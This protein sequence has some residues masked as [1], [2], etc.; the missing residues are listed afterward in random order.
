MT[1][2]NRWA[3]PTVSDVAWPLDSIPAYVN[4]DMVDAALAAGTGGPVAIAAIGCTP[5]LV[6]TELEGDTDPVRYWICH[7]LLM[8]TVA[9]A[10]AGL[11]VAMRVT[12]IGMADQKDE[13]DSVRAEY[14][15]RVVQYASEC[16]KEAPC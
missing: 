14:L 9:S 13:P 3:T 10:E 15:A 16:I 2:Y 11:V 12:S 4:R 5:I 7:A 6:T 8:D 1:A